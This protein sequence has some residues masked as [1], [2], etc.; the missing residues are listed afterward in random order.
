MQY[1]FYE[2][3]TLKYICTNFVLKGVNVTHSIWYADQ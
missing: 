1:V 2:V 3:Q